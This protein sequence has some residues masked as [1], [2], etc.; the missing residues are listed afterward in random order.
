VTAVLIGIVSAGPASAHTSLKSASPAAGSTVGPPTQIVLT[1]DD[2]VRFTQVLLTDA[3]GHRY[4]SGGTVNVDN[5]VTEHISRA[6]PNGRYTVAWRVVAPDGHPVE[7]TYEF[8]VA[9]SSA[10]A[11]AGA[12]AP[13]AGQPAGTGSS[14]TSMWWIVVIVVLIA[15]AAVGGVLLLRQSTSDESGAESAAG[16]SDAE[17]AA[18]APA[19]TETGA[20]H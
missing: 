16:D 13:A 10:A 1:Y 19:D 6:L 4:Q 17:A 9:G 8:T 18:K 7:G 12:P 20:D 3:A 11:P 14:G 15:A 2:T 5:T